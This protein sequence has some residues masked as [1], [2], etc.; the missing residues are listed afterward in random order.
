M[1]MTSNLLT[2]SVVCALG[3]AFAPISWG[4]ANQDTTKGNDNQKT[5]GKTDDNKG[6]MRTETIHGIVSAITAEGEIALDYKNKRAVEV[7]AAFLTV[8][9]T[10]V[11]HEKAE[12]GRSDQA[13]SSGKHDAA[14]RH[15]YNVYQV[16]ISPKTK[17]CE[18]TAEMSKNAQDQS[19]SPGDKK[20]CNL[21]QLEVGDHVQIEFVTNAEAW[22]S[23]KL[24][25]QT[26]KMRE[27][28]GRHR[29]HIG[30]A[31]EVSIMIAKDEGRNENSRPRDRDSRNRNSDNK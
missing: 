16:W 3:I 19:N 22:D 8:V 26:D 14:G 11:R 21:D 18:C 7:D 15:R 25:H 31:K 28:H 20:E 12:A 24:A 29:T 2:A 23:S 4:Q 1:R 6:S 10:P 30:Y 5:A 27:K 13:T 17:V 9:G